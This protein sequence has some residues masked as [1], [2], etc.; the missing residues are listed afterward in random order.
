[1]TATAT[2][3]P[4]AA[5]FEKSETPTL[6]D[7]A[8]A[9]ATATTDDDEKAGAGADGAPPPPPPPPPGP[10]AHFGAAG[11]PPDGGLQAWLQVAGAFMVLFNTWGILNTFGVFQTYYESGVL[12]RQSSSN[13]SW[14]GA[15]QAFFVLVGGVLSGPIYDRGHLRPLLITGSF[16]VVFGHMMLSICK[17]YWQAVLAQGVCVGLGAGLLFTPALAVLPTWFSSRLGLAVGIAASGSSFGGIIY[18]IVFYRLISDIGFG[19]SVRVLG[20]IALATA[21]IPIV[22][23]RPRVRPARVRAMVDWAA[24]ADGPFMLFVAGSLI[25]FVALYVFLFYQSYYGEA[26]GLTDASLSF[27]LV[28]ILNAGSMFGRTLPNWLSDKTG[29]LNIII[30]G[31]LACSLLLFVMQAVHSTAGIVVVVLL[32]GF[33]SG[34]F[35][36][37][38]PVIFVQLTADKSMI[39]T[40]IGM[41][42]AL[43]AFSTF[44]GGPGAGGVLG[45]DGGLNWTGLWSYGGATMAAAAIRH[46]CPADGRQEHD[47]DAHRH[48]LCAHCV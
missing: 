18:P 15:L 4:G 46:L 2:T 3:T 27:Y 10:H 39:G 9:P 13:I 26:T 47:W 48:G 1:M 42:F 5:A 38:P 34:V 7:V 20:F 41:G 31:A 17:T 24:F 21:L 12:F 22:L 36:A 40:R 11:P 32:F 33:F 35:I 8:A 16:G 6:A 23:M 19:W 30:P 44:A 45:S 28:P 29:P 14:I 37:L 43:I 25:G